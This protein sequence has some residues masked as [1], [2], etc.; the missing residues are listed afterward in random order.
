MGGGR[1]A[2]T[3]TLTL[4]G[5][6]V[7]MDGEDMMGIGKDEGV[8]ESLIVSGV[9][10]AEDSK[11][12]VRLSEETLGLEEEDEEESERRGGRDGGSEGILESREDAGVGGSSSDSD[13]DGDDSVGS[14]KEGIKSSLLQ[15]DAETW[16]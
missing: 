9:D 2:V 16:R 1:D 12:L 10:S 11:A 6:V 14:V 13:I 4:G 8:L 7:V 3:L 5:E 15:D